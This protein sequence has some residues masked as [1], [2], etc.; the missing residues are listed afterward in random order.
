MTTF[1]PSATQS[2]FTLPAIRI[3]EALRH[4][5]LKAKTKR[6]LNQLSCEQLK[7]IGL[8]R[9]TKLLSSTLNRQ[10]W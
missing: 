10:L 2:K 9:D 6:V 4:F 3:S 7:D 1:Q 5:L 8:Y